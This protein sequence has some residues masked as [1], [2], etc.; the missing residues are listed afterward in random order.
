[1][2]VEIIKNLII[3][4]I[5]GNRCELWQFRFV[6]HH[7]FFEILPSNIAHF[8]QP[9]HKYFEGQNIGSLYWLKGQEWRQEITVVVRL[10]IRNGTADKAAGLIQVTEP[11]LQ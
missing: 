8:G 1:M 11:V 9:Y 6:I 3:T 10:K 7:L 2:I 4:I 5:A